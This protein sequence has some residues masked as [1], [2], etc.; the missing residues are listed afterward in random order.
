MC[1]AAGQC[2]LVF[3]QRIVPDK[4]QVQAYLKAFRF[5]LN[6]M[7]TN[8]R[9]KE[10]DKILTM[11]ALMMRT[12]RPNVFL[13]S[14]VLVSVVGDWVIETLMRYDSGRNRLFPNRV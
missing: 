1:S 3:V 7:V 12:Y 9:Y 13:Q 5:I 2:L 6:P 10:I 11:E 4:N 14:T 8:K